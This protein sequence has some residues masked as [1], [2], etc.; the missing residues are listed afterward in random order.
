[1]NDLAHAVAQLINDWGGFIVVVVFLGG[2][3]VI[4]RALSG[5]RANQKLRGELK[6]TKAETARLHEL[7]SNTSRALGSGQGRGNAEVAALAEQ[8]RAALDDRAHALDLL[9]QIQA[10]GRAWPQLPQE[11]RDEIDQALL[12]LRARPAGIDA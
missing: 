6:A 2:G 8:A 7:M 11:L 10:T 12:R 3:D 5:R 1:M 4:G 9:S